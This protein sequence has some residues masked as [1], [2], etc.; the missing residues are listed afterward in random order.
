MD[1][2]WQA[3]VDFPAQAARVVL[4]ALRATAGQS[5]PLLA[6][7]LL[8]GWLIHLTAALLEKNAVGLLGIRAYLFI[9]GWTGTLIH[10][11]GHAMFCLPFGHRITGMRLF[12]FNT[13]GKDVGYVS[14]SFNRRNPWHLA[15]NFFISVGPV[16]LGALTVFMVLR[17][18]AGLPLNLAGMYEAGRG[19]STDGTLIDGAMGWLG[20]FRKSFMHLWIGIGSNLDFTDWRLYVAVWLVLG[21]GSGM[22]LS[23][24]DIRLAASGLMVI[25]ALLFAVNVV[26][27]LV[28]AQAPSISPVIPPAAALAFLMSCV[29]CVCAVGALVFRLLRLLFR[30]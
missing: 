24:G 30:R 11:L 25:L 6:P 8:L 19:I 22:S 20:L 28:R 2:V 27:V 4:P 13:R 23:A 21:V 3:I 10:E 15:G 14:H 7:L 9:L 16:L 12:S 26:L 17:Y 1:T 5:V 29:L 18:L